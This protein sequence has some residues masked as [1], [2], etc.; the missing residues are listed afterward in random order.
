MKAFRAIALF[1]FAVFAL[2]LASV[3]KSDT[4]A[5]KNGDHL[6]G[7]ISDSDSKSLTL[8]T[9]YA[10][11]VKV[12]WSAI[13]EVSSA[14]PVYVVTND[15]K[16]VSGTVAPEG[17]N[18]VVHTTSDTSVEVPLD[19][20]A[21]VRSTEGQQAYEKTLHPGLL[22]DWKGGATAGFA[23]ARGNSD[24][25]NLNTGFTADRKTLSDEIAVTESSIY[26]TNNAPGGGVTANAILGSAR[27]DRN[28]TPSFFAFG[29]GDFTHDELQ[30][31]TLREIYTGGLGWHAV[32]HP[33]TAFDVLAGINYTRETYSPA[34]G[35]ILTS[36]LDRNL[37]GL[38]VGQTFMHKFAG[39]STI[40]ESSYFYPDFDD[41]SQ[42]RFSF[43]AAAV[44]KISKWFGWQ[45]TVGD[46]YVTNPP[47][48][49]T[50]SN[51]VILSTGLNVTIAH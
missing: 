49:G 14:K 42:Y 10:G 33:N 32:K 44:T 23:I 40:T 43:D 8:K 2:L 6:T 7:S 12:Q 28:F 25:T 30:D 37:P 29:S 31:L 16:T 45:V 22:H 27:Y 20:V 21:F 48:L 13:K 39:G 35:A 18:L 9:D 50:K 26:A 51:D 5:L 1:V 24:T 46:R 41:F 17:P 47:V 19:K 3:A 36:S 38:T 4:V 15:K 11:D 34:A